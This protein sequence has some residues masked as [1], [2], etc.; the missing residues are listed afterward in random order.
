MGL[1]GAIPWLP[2]GEEVAQ[3]ADAYITTIAKAAQLPHGPGSVIHIGLPIGAAITG[4]VDRSHIGGQLGLI[5]PQSRD[6]VRLTWQLGIKEKTAPVLAAV[7]GVQQQTRLAG[8]PALIAAEIKA[9]QTEVFLFRQI[10]G[11]LSPAGTAIVG[12]Q[13]QP[14]AAHQEAV[15]VIG[16]GHIQGIG[17]CGQRHGLPGAC[18]CHRQPGGD[19]A[20]EGKAQPSNEQQ[21]H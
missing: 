7:R 16:K 12:F 9:D 5:W 19:T 18:G 10:E 17:L 6:Q 21:A 14:V 20:G 1:P 3:A 2:S 4:L 13:Y 15:A 8:N 11:P